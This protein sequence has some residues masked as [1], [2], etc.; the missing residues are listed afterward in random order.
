MLMYVP[1]FKENYDDVLSQHIKKIKKIKIIM[2]FV[3]KKI[4]T[5][6][7]AKSTGAAICDCQI[8]D[9]PQQQNS[10]AQLVKLQLGVPGDQGSSPACFN[11]N[12]FLSAVTE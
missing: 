5:E 3:D 1:F 11:F 2:I 4:Q 9:L 10:I 6:N 7:F 8:G 12:F